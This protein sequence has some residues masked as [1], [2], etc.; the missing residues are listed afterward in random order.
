MTLAK[1]L[2]NSRRSG[3]RGAA[4]VEFSLSFVLF[5]LLVFAVMEGGKLIWTWTT[6]QHG[7]REGARLAIMQAD[8]ASVDTNITNIVKARTIG[9]PSG[10]IS[11]AT[12]WGG[13]DGGDVVSI[14]ASCPVPI[15]FGGLVFGPSSINLQATSSAVIVEP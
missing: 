8:N 15:M 13:T 6:L 14:T 1:R 9:I 4:M 12:V 5:I 7:V 11:V 2:I 10:D 3:R